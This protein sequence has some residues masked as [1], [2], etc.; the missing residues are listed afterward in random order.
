MGLS[1]IKEGGKEFPKVAANKVHLAR[2]VGVTSFG[3]QQDTYQGETTTKEKVYIEFETPNDTFNN[4]GSVIP[5]RIGKEMTLS[6]SEK[7]FLKTIFDAAA[8]GSKN[9]KDLL[10]KVVQIQVGLT[11]GGNP[12]V[13]NVM[14]VPDGTTIK[15]FN[16]ETYLFDFDNPDIKALSLIPKFIANKIPSALNFKGSKIE[17]LLSSSAGS[18]STD[19]GIE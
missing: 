5:K 6:T 14:G 9:A 11:S 3:I 10:G 16:T 2:I 17:Q 12:K 19:V 1:N 15:E 7:S 13:T 4:E 18:A 8:P